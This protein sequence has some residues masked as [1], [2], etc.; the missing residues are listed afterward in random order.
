MKVQQGKR[1]GIVR[2]GLFNLLMRLLISPLAFVF[3]L[4]IAKYLSSISIDTFG[5]WQSIYVL[6]T[7][8]FLVPAD[9][10]SAIA[11]RYA[12]EGKKIGGLIAINSLAGAV[13][14]SVYFIIV[15]FLSSFGGSEYEVYFYDAGILLFLYYVLDITKAVSL[16]KSPRVNAIGN[17]AFQL[18]RLVTAVVFIYKFNLSILAVILAY[19]LGYLSQILTYVKFTKADFSVDF[20]IAIASIR[21]SVVFITSYIQGIIEASMIWIAVYLLRSYDPVSYFESALIISNIVIWSSSASDGL[22]LKLAESKDARVLETALKLF[23]AV[24][25]LFLLF[26]VVDGLPLLY[27][28][29]S[30]YISAFTALTILSVSNFVRSIYGIFYRAIYMADVTLNVESTE[31]LRG[32]TARLIRSNVLISAIGVVL[33]GGIIYFLSKSDLSPSYGYPLVATVISVGLLVNSLGMVITSFLA[34]K[35]LYNFNFPLKEAIVPILAT[36]VVSLLFL[37]W[38]SIHGM[39]KL[40]TLEEIKEILLISLASGSLYLAINWILNPYVKELVKRV[41]MEIK[42]L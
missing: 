1:T 12:A 36:A 6:I 3:S 26:A 41:I 23:F 22:I 42:N 27:I 28:L 30:D 7:G 20:K 32:P 13:V 14:L 10:L 38:F 34:A 29:R 16:G 40:R 15:P 17:V 37:T 9:V 25:S 39:P 24:G 8:Y 5:A 4:L 11:G 18:V 31:E 21:K 33:S 19:S 2:I 35:K